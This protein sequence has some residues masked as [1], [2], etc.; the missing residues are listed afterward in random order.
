M[1][2]GESE[3][4]KEVAVTSELRLRQN[5]LSVLLPAVVRSSWKW[6]P[7]RKPFRV[8]SLLPPTPAD[9]SDWQGQHSFA[10]SVLTIWRFDSRLYPH[11]FRAGRAP[12]LSEKQETFISRLAGFLWEPAS[13]VRDW[14]P[15]AARTHR[16][17]PRL[18]CGWERPRKTE[19]CRFFLN[20]LL[21]FPASATT[22]R[23][24]GVGGWSNIPDWEP[25][26]VLAGLTVSS[27]WSLR[28]LCVYLHP[29][30]QGPP[31]LL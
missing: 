5:P 25:F 3:P 13:A 1:T 28:S 29:P 6:T 21:T 8:V 14:K 10:I 16:K 7:D 30:N 20:T 11:V 4:R 15:L 2:L 31:E 9:N 18:L 26:M 12:S 19:C 17:I 24:T 23:E 22:L 27:D